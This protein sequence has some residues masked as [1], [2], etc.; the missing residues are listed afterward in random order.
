MAVP[1]RGGSPRWIAGWRTSARRRSG[2]REAEE[3][4]AIFIYRVK[5][6]GSELQKMIPTPMLFPFGVSPDGRWVPAADALPETA[7]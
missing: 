2:V 5:E 7:T 6:D 3:K 4:G 1:R